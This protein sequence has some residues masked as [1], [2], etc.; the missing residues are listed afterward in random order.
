M[1]RLAILA[2]GSRF[3]DAR[4]TPSIVFWLLTQPLASGC[5]LSVFLTAESR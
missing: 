1:L 5:Q 2:A 3:P 4:K